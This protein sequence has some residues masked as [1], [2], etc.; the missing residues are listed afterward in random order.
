MKLIDREDFIALVKLGVSSKV[1][2]LE[3]DLS[4][5][6]LLSL[7]KSISIREELVKIL[8]SKDSQELQKL[9]KRYR[10]KDIL[11]EYVASFS[12]NKEDEFFGR[13]DVEERLRFDSL[14]DEYGI[15]LVKQGIK[16]EGDKK[17]IKRD[18]IKSLSDEEIS[19]LRDRAE[20]GTI[21]QKNIFAFT[22][23]KSGRIDEARDYLIDLV[24]TSKSYTAFRQLIYLEKT[25]G[26]LEDAKIWALEAEE[27]FSDNLGIK[28]VQ[29]RIAREEGNV[30]EM[31][32]LAKQ[33]KKINP[34]NTKYED[35]VN[36]VKIEL[37]EK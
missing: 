19:F 15:K 2:K 23:F 34:Q 4:D 31:I 14:L 9:I 32:E 20:K 13:L 28:E 24:D 26:N 17:L 1:L 12:E 16:K 7:K 29:F 3:F 22:L 33:I 25:E 18:G 27:Q 21:N 36:R 37:D 11:V 8:E 35:E 5:E 10:K 6:D 30:G